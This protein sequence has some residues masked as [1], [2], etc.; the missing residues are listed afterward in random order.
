MSRASWSEFRPTIQFTT[1]VLCENAHHHADYSS[2]QWAVTILVGYTRRAQFSQNL[3]CPQGTK[4][5]P[6]MSANKHSLLHIHNTVMVCLQQLAFLVPAVCS[7]SSSSFSSPSFSICKRVN[8]QLSNFVVSPA[9]CSHHFQADSRRPTD[10]LTPITH[11]VN[12][13]MALS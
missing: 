5:K 9:P 2:A 4:A 7:C 11:P 13:P 1:A 8:G 3:A 12:P 10:D 6:S